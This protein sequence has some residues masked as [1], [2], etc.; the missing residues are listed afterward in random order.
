MK[1][2]VLIALVLV[3]AVTFAFAAFQAP[4]LGADGYAVGWNNWAT[5]N[6]AFDTSSEPAQTVAFLVLPPRPPLPCVGWNS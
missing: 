2:V 1:K 6:I 3:L 4:S 5:R